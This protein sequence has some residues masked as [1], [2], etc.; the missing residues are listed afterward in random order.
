M[1]FDQPTNIAICKDRLSVL[2]TEFFEFYSKFDFVR[3]TVS[4]FEGCA[5]SQEIY[6]TRDKLPDSVLR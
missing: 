1:G 5:I 4:P 2:L 3:N 6:V